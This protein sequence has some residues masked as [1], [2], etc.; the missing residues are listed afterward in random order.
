LS[1]LVGGSG[2]DVEENSPLD[3]ALG[4]YF[5]KPWRLL[6]KV[7][8]DPKNSLKSSVSHWSSLG[9]LGITSKEVLLITSS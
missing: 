4:R 7:S 2:D 3:S 1:E 6:E 5:R 9:A 8:S